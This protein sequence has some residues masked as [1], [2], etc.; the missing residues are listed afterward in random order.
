[1]A[2]IA[3][4]HYARAVKNLQPAIKAAM[5]TEQ[6]KDNALVGAIV[7][8]AALPLWSLYSSRFIPEHDGAVWSGG[9]CWAD[10]PI[11]MHIAESFLSGRN[12]DVSFGSMHS[13]VFA[14]EVMAYPFI[15]DFHA[16][17]LTK[18]GA[19]L[20]WSFLLPGYLLCLT[21]LA[22]LALFTIRVTQSR[23]G[24]VLAILITLGAGGMGGWHL[25][26]RDGFWNAVNVDTAQNDV[27]GDG[28]IFWF[29]FLPHVLLPQR[30]AN[31]AYPLVLFV[32]LLVWRA[33]DHGMPL[34][35]SQRRTLL[36]TAGLCAGC[37]PLVQAHAFVAL[38]I[39]IGTLFVMDVHKWM[40]QPQMLLSWV[41]AGV[42]AV[43]VGYPQLRVFQHQVESGSGGHFMKFGWIYANHDVGRPAGLKG[44]F[45]F[46]WYSLGPA[47]PM[48]ILSVA[49]QAWEVMTAAYVAY[50]VRHANA[51]ALDQVYSK[52]QIASVDL[53][54]AERHESTVASGGRPAAPGGSS[55][56]DD[57]HL[58]SAKSLS[59]STTA[60]HDDSDS[61]ANSSLTGSSAGGRGGL[62][63]RGATRD[64][65]PEE[66]GT[67]QLQVRIEHLE[68]EY[69][70]PMGGADGAMTTKLKLEVPADTGAVLV[71]DLQATGFTGTPGTT[72]TASGHAMGS[73]SVYKPKYF[74]EAA[75]NAIS[76]AQQR[77]NPD[78][79]SASSAGGRVAVAYAVQDTKKKPFL[80]EHLLVKLQS[81]LDVNL[82]DLSRIERYSWLGLDRWLFPLNH[83]SLSGRGFDALKL[84]V[85]ASLVF[86]VG[87]YINF[88]PWDRDNCK[89]L[90]VW[91]FINSAFTG[92]LLAA[93]VEMLL[94][95]AH[96]AARLLSIVPGL[97]TQ[98]LWIARGTAAMPEALYPESARVERP[99]VQ[100]KAATASGKPSS[101][102]RSSMASVC[103]A[104]SPIMILG[105]LAALAGM[106]LTGFMM[107][108]REYG[109][110]HVMLDEQQLVTGAWIKEHVPPKAVVVHKDVHITPS[111]SIAGRPTLVAYTG[112]CCRFF[113]GSCSRH[114]A[115]SDSSCSQLNC[116]DSLQVGCGATA[117]TT[118]SVTRTATTSWRT[119]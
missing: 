88:Q 51:Q 49:V 56:K 31:F 13:P 59:H 111:G 44:F 30:G 90:Y 10:L 70:V 15:P 75:L 69:A 25:A 79:G 57:G 112:K 116:C 48:F 100:P 40:A 67:T 17:V 98:A 97:Q 4:E 91:V 53:D 6:I 85:A 8:V 87:N 84:C 108:M 43:A 86:L 55:K 36:V 74:G 37:L 94:N 42:V 9:S 68:L 118:M 101:G 114:L 95:S 7:A 3:Y 12:Q 20:R 34:S 73:V 113:C 16:A 60:S 18:I 35:V 82:S 52:A 109:L 61:S 23:V 32:L 54:T 107:I 80:V 99:G 46:W 110:N 39:I 1:M 93:P 105:G 64:S 14:G 5:S 96:G 106:C 50:T 81:G 11:H 66:A 21:L 62:T 89:L 65:E 92:A 119:R 103:T 19:T 77:V 29:A 115:P 102:K 33:M 28:K 78:E 76:P 26:Q 104:A 71:R 63:K 2:Y 38:A 72:Y 22:F 24:A 41:L 45:T 27:S 58:L 117:T 83:L 47:V